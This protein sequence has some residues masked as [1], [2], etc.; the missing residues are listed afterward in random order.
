METD[1]QIDNKEWNQLKAS[2]PR[3]GDSPLSFD[4]KLVAKIK[5]DKIAPRPRWHFLLKN[6][7]IWIVGVASLLIGASAV[8]V[9]IYL[10]EYNDWEI[11]DQTRKGFGEFFL[12]TLPYFW[13]IFL[14][15]FIYILYYNFKHTKRGYRYPVWLISLVSILIS[16]ILGAALFF[17]GVGEDIDEILGAQAPWYGQVINQQIVFWFNPSEGRLTGVVVDNNESDNFTIIDPSGEAWQVSST[18][19]NLPSHLIPVG[20]PV[21]MIGRVLAEK[22]FL[23]S[24]VKPVHPGRGFFKRPGFM[25]RPSRGQCLDGSCP[26]PPPPGIMMPGRSPLN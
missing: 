17:S 16:V 25:P 15:F 3:A 21:R 24:L 9:M 22:H 14:G 4:Q 8:S 1:R 2:G 6:Y 18:N 12:L 11:Y 23:A 26:I 10:F 7:V 19:K 5:E 20:S 13:L